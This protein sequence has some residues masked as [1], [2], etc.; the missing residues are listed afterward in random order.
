[1]SQIIFTS[2]TVSIIA[3]T[4]K[5]TK[6]RTRAEAYDMIKR[7][8]LRLKQ[9][10]LPTT[11]LAADVRLPRTAIISLLW[12]IR[13]VALAQWKAARAAAPATELVYVADDEGNA[14]FV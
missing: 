1:M 13:K 6:E 7:C 2:D 12:K 10:A 3:K 8:D 11:E 4:A 5:S 14:L 9:L